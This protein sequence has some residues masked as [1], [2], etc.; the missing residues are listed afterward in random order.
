MNKKKLR[1]GDLFAGVGGFSLGFLREG[2]ELV[3]A[4]E[5]DKTC[6]KV[7]RKRHPHTKLFGD[8]T[9]VSENDLE[10]VDIIIGGS[11][12]QD[13]SV[14]GKRKGLEGERSGLF[15][16]FIRLVRA[17]RPR[18]VV[19][20]N[21]PGALSS[22]GGRDFSVV[23]GEM[24][25]SGYPDIAYRVLDARYFGVAQR[26]R[27]VFIVASSE[28]VGSPSESIA[29]RVLGL[30]EP[31]CSQQE[32]LRRHIE[33]CRAA[34]QAPPPNAARSAYAAGGKGGSGEHASRTRAEHI[35]NRRGEQGCPQSKVQADRQVEEALEDGGGEGGV[36]QSKFFAADGGGKWWGS[37]ELGHEIGAQSSGLSSHDNQS[38]ATIRNEL[39][40]ETP[41][42]S[43]HGFRYVNQ[44]TGI[45][46]TDEVASLRSCMGRAGVHEF[47]HPVVAQHDPLAIRL[48]Q[49]GANGVGVSNDAYTL[50]GSSP[51]AIMQSQ[52]IQTLSFQP[53]FFTRDQRTGSADSCNSDVVAPLTAGGLGDSANH[54]AI[55]GGQ[56]AQAY[57]IRED[58]GNNTFS[59]TPLEVANAL[60]ALQAAPSSHHAQTYV[61][62]V[63]ASHG[64][65]ATVG[66]LCASDWKGIRNQ[67]IHEDKCIVQNHSSVAA[68][69]DGMNQK[70]NSEVYH[71]LRIGKD[72]GDCIVS[73]PEVFRKS[74]RA[75][76]AHDSE[77]W[78]PAEQSNT[79]NAFDT[80]ERDTHAVAFNTK[81]NQTA[82]TEVA[83]HNKTTLP[84]MGNS[85]DGS[86]SEKASGLKG[87]NAKSHSA[88]SKNHMCHS[89]TE[90]SAD[91][92]GQDECHADSDMVVRRLTPVE[93]CI[94]MGWPHDW[95]EFGME[96]DGRIVAISD[97]Q[98]YKQCGN[99]VVSNCS[100]WIAAGIIAIEDGAK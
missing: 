80:G 76:S 22:N 39:S 63:N 17:K 67:S 11:P 42:T 31:I 56:L 3:W 90:K 29:A 96:E 79:L 74:R 70:M 98:R 10:D 85:E 4:V 49:T 7:L 16:E 93:C 87:G 33:A 41:K 64:D 37:P 47:N 57:S 77:S 46:P 58:A 13:L 6:Q 43:S 19:W 92:S 59:A 61:T 15:H 9:G 53:R 95:N 12:C 73:T 25:D 62:Y 75:Q 72:S 20:E 24:A 65:G 1:V 48:G 28:A 21:V 5:W 14:A 51:Q 38:Q 69:Y 30:L 54:V 40:G 71:S 66:A 50:D 78:V 97:S 86:E 32:S 8:I 35:D 36:G 99:G 34:G 100:Q 23:L 55:S 44:N 88:S 26:R 52:D 45:V 27:R 68:G 89:G 81:T 60:Q 91:I 83:E 2:C 82:R 18:W 84:D 94:L